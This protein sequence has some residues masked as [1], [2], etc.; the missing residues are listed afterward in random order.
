[1]LAF[2]KLPPYIEVVE[3]DP[4]PGWKVRKVKFNIPIPWSFSNITFDAANQLRA[5]LDQ[6]GFA[7][8]IASGNAGRKAHFPF[9]DDLLQSASRK[10]QQSKD[11][12]EVIFNLMLTFQPYFGGN[13]S[14]WGLNKLCNANKHEVTLKPVIKSGIVQLQRG[15]VVGPAAITNIWDMASNELVLSRVGPGGS[16]SGDINYSFS[17]LVGDPKHTGG[18]PVV[19]YLDE[20]A[21]DVERIL[22][23]IDREAIGLGL[24]T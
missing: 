1:M 14:L 3:D 15:T 5:A 13:N 17:L 19:Q 20:V 7:V 18:K 4:E 16:V 8:A 11:I 9:G 24:F 23:A 21:Q 6:A 22:E 12:P 10:T 2:D